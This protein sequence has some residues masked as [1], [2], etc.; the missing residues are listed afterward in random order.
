MPISNGPRPTPSKVMAMTKIA[1]AWARRLAGNKWVIAPRHGVAHHT[2][3][4]PNAL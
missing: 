1:V 4:K 3:K 2:P